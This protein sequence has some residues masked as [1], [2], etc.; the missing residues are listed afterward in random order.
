MR[1]ALQAATA[2]EKTL[3]EREAEVTELKSE[4]AK[5][6]QAQ[7]KA[8]DLEVKVAELGDEIKTVS[9]SS[10]VAART[11][12]ADETPAQGY[13]TSACG[14]WHHRSRKEDSRIPAHH[15]GTV[16]RKR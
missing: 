15:T 12:L 3:A 7:Q 2:N 16:L 9:V 5:L 10:R 11:F 1:S 6:Q 13:P 4:I 8:A 14:K